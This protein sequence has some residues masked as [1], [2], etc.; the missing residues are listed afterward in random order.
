LFSN[1]LSLSEISPLLLQRKDV[2]LTQGVKKKAPPLLK[3]RDRE[4]RQPLAAIAF[5]EEKKTIE[6]KSTERDL[7]LGGN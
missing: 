3:G 4:L 7:F 1:S 5:K 6:K 2:I